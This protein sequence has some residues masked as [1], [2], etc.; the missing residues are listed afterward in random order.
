MLKQVS[1]AC[2]LA[3]ILISLNPL[4]LRGQ[5]VASA[6]ISGVITDASGAAVPGA[7]VTATQMDTGLVRTTLTSSSGSYSLPNLPVGPYSLQ[8]KATGFATYVRSGV[9]LQVSNNI[10]LNVTL[11]LGQVTQQVQVKANASMV[12]TQ[13]TAVA[14]V[15]D[16]R[17]IVELPLNGRQAT[18]L[19]LL[20][21]ASYNTQNGSLASSKN[22][23]TSVTISVAG[24]QVNGTNYL[25][26]GGD[27]N[28][29]FTNVNMPFP[30]PDAIQEFSVQT[31]S[32]SARYGVHPGAVVNVVT[33]SGTNQIHGDL[34]E[35]VRNG[36]FNA[37]D[38]FAARQDTLRRNQFGGTVGGPLRKDK[39]FGFFGYQG[40][41][42]RTAPAQNISFVPTQAALGGDFSAL[43]SASCQ[44]S[45]QARTIINPATGQPFANDFVSPSLFNPQALA[46]LKYVPVA[47]NSCGQVTY[48]IPNPQDEDQYIGRVDWNVSAKHQ[49]FGRYFI[50]NYNNPPVFNN[51]LLLS[52]RPG[53]NDRGQSAVLGDTY[54][55]GPTTLNSAH[56]TWSRMR[57]NRGPASDLIS[58]RSVG[59]NIFNLVPNSITLGVNGYFSA[60][61]GTCAPGFFN[62]NSFQLADDVD[63]IKGRHHLSFGADWIHNQL[64]EINVGIGNGSYTFSGQ[65]SG[66]ALLDFMLGL[67]SG[68][69][70]GLPEDFNPRQNYLGA[71]VQD[72]VRVSSRLNFY[73]GLRWEPFF[74]ETDVF[75]RGSH[76]SPAAFAAGTK[77]SR[78]VNA[79]PG[80]LF[81]GDP[82]IPTGYA[83]NK[84]S[85]FEPRVG[86]V[87]DPSGNGHQT[88]RAGLGFFSD[89]PLIFY[90]VR[91][92]DAP[93]WG[94]SISLSSPAGGLTNPYLGYPGGNPFPLP[95]PPSRNQVFPPEGVY[96][97]MPLN[98]H[99]TQ[100]TQWDLTYQRQLSNNWMV[101]ATYIG[102]KT[103]HV[104]VGSEQDP[105][106]YIPGSCNGKP[107]S[108]V[109]NTNQ[110]RLLYVENPVAGSLYSTIGLLDDGSNA[111]YNAM[112]LTA[113]HRF[114]THY[115]ILA[116]YT[117]SHCLSEGDTLGGPGGPSQQNPFDRNADRGNCNFDVRHIVNLSLVAT[118]PRFANPWTNRLLGGWQIA[119]VISV[120]SGL[121][122]SPMTGVDNSLTGVNLDRPNLV[123]DPY[124]RNTS[125]R[126][127]ITARAYLPNT[128]GTFGN[129]G[130]DSLE[131]PGYFDI[132]A[133]VSK[134][135][136]VREHQQLELRF[137]FFNLGNNVNF[138]N[139]DN[140]LRDS[141]FG[142]ITSDVSPRI[143]QFALK[144]Y[145]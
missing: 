53:I 93:P 31:N 81:T 62:D 113:Q 38:F 127:W 97:N 92:A 3:L 107:C 109:A 126:Q 70:Q 95:L 144:Y 36:A 77:T 114:S 105:A 40:T 89:L 68:F 101:S 47:S 98:L 6:E 67:P 106:V 124:L 35:F 7:K 19:V 54:S 1:F 13:S 23:P 2:I 18:Q 78:Y 44:H 143:L 48:G 80:L 131:G 9:L 145:F 76:F 33:K 39:L 83:Y 59:I 24:G 65:L 111:E 57:I 50:S 72:N 12:Q 90:M 27:N 110:R 69:T 73:A 34:F 84:I 116:N 118:M 49:F 137:E 128:I 125:T 43:E 133:G 86:L 10:T 134:F 28:D 25:M 121:W 117:Y 136:N 129:A 60:G 22:Y 103:S 119:P 37:R 71:Y 100:M 74:P 14:Q 61:C 8:V 91:F 32:L 4:Y 16:Q 138:N 64:N 51:D 52:T 58:P 132:D 56:I 5:A 41:R 120:H 29:A 21:G 99:P 122:F 85:V 112:L 82:G 20:S 123:S 135:F 26:D 79:P 66:D 17:R 88:L 46:I 130:R 104:W 140:S 87:W 96:V 30:F 15:I 55:I 142:L 102:N 11:Q 42:T 141:T 139:P 94:S 75:G 63:M 115:T 45:G 108:T